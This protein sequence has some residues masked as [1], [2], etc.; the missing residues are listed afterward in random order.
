[1]TLQGDHDCSRKLKHICRSYSHP[2][3]VQN[4]EISEEPAPEDSATFERLACKLRPFTQLQG[5][6]YAL[7][8]NTI[9]S[10]DEAVVPCGWRTRTLYTFAWLQDYSERERS[11]RW[12]MMVLLSKRIEVPWE[13]SVLVLG[14]REVREHSNIELV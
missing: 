3:L 8:L 7:Q 13:S 1:M 11:K 4:K 6:I 12:K 5:A 9:S 2:L 14:K 10:P